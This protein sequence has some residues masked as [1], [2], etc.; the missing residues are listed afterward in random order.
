MKKLLRIQAKAM[1]QVYHAITGKEASAL[2]EKKVLSLQ[3]Y[4][5]AKC[6]LLYCSNWSEVMTE[7]LI[8]KT[9]SKKGFCALPYVE[10]KTLGIA[11]IFD[12]SKLVFGKF[13]IREP[14]RESI[15]TPE[16][17]DFALVP[18][19][20]FDHE[21]SRLGYGHGY[22][23]RL[24]RKLS[25]PIVGLAY[26]VQILDRIPCEDCDVPVQRIVTENRTIE[27]Y[28]RQPVLPR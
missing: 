13:G 28:K 14:P 12:M 19:V 23:D 9:I 11:K 2:V 21:G 16:E 26:E 20:A 25:C 5:R 6:V 4:T 8:A 1:R 22:Y 24:L 10:G 7:G 17:V 27:C 15:V 3:E 18:G